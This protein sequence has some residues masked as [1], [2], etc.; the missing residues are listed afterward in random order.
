MFP[1]VLE[2]GRNTESIALR[3]GWNTLW[4]RKMAVS[5]WTHRVLQKLNNGLNMAENKSAG[6]KLSASIS[7]V[8]NCGEHHIHP[9]VNSPTKEEEECSSSLCSWVSLTLGCTLTWTPVSLFHPDVTV[10]L[11]YSSLW[12]Q[13]RQAHTALSTEAGIVIVA[14]LHGIFVVLLPKAAKPTKS[15]GNRV[16]RYPSPLPTASLEGPED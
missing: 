13:E 14:L 10:A 7:P 8:S 1:W 15:R 6:T 11:G 3:V 9:Q 4:K 2:Q 12:V 16:P 5:L